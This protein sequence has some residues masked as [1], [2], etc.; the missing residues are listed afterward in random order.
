M[1]SGVCLC[2][3]QT[4]AAR[5][6]AD[7]RPRAVMLSSAL[8]PPSTITSGPGAADTGRRG[9]FGR[10]HIYITCIESLVLTLRCYI[11]EYNHNYCG[12]HYKLPYFENQSLVETYNWILFSHTSVKLI[13]PV[14][15]WNIWLGYDPKPIPFPTTHLVILSL[16]APIVGLIEGGLADWLAADPGHNNAYLW[17]SPA[18]CNCLFKWGPLFFFFFFSSRPP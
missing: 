5:P 16:P 11:V 1:L 3:W 13:H 12:K 17:L 2:W 15:H 18:P 14:T 7:S 6:P 8:L 4:S 9:L 10:T